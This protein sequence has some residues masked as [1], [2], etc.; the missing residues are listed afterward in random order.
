MCCKKNHANIRIIGTWIISVCGQSDCRTKEGKTLGEYILDPNG[1]EGIIEE[2]GFAVE[3]ENKSY[4]IPPDKR[5]IKGLG[6]KIQEIIL[7]W[8]HYY[9]DK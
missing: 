8:Q 1:M 7:K 9:T 2:D 6:T 4:Q 3:I 5:I